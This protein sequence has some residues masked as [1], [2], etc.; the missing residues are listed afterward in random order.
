MTR[1]LSVVV[2]LLAVIAVAFAVLGWWSAR[3]A[4]ATAGVRDGRLAACAAA[5]HCVCSDVGTSSDSVH[6]VEAIAVPAV[7]DEV[8]WRVIRE[9]LAAS[10][11][12][13]VAQDAG[14]LHATYTSSLFRFV[15]DLELRMDGARLQLRSTSRVGYSDLGANRQRVEDLRVR[16]SAA[17]IGVKA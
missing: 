5:P 14:Y 10:G 13:T 9:V 17:F 6:W 15:D 3:M 16:L 1:I 7:S 4:P 12:R 2:S 8:R 11:A